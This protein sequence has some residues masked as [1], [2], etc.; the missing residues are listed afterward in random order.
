[1]KAVPKVNT[2][3]LYLEDELVDDAFSGV[4]P[5][6]AEQEP[7]IF[8]PDQA[9]QP[10]ALEEEIEPEIA[11]YLVGVPVPAGLFHPRFDLAAWEAYQD[12]VQVE[13][14]KIFPDL[15]VEGLSQ[16]EIDELTKPQPEELSELDLLKQRLA[17][18]E[19]ENKRLAEESNAN[20]LALMELHM[21]VL[22]VVPPNEG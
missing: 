19:A 9:E 16:E 5:F 11:G 21:L 14:Q 8:D 12:A 18:S 6:Y 17:E 15:W 22:S 3:G 20:Q 7:V 13:P 2:D 10:E 1:M 4:I